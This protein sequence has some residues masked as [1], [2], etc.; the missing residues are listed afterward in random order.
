M[1]NIENTPVIRWISEH[2]L[3]W[4]D[5]VGPNKYLQALIVTVIFLLLAKMADFIKW[6][7]LAKV[8]A[9]TSTKVDDYVVKSLH[10]P[11]KTT[12]V[13]IGLG[14]ATLLLELPPAGRYLVIGILRTIVIFVWLRFAIQVCSD[15][16][17]YVSKNRDRSELV[18]AAT[19]PLFNNVS[20]IALIALAIYVFM[21]AWEINVTAWLASAGIVGLALSFAA[22]D[23]I[24]NLFAGMAILVDAPYKLGDF[25]IL[26]TG[27]RGEVTSIGM[28]ST[29]ILTLEDV[30]IT[31]PNGLMGNSKIINQSGGPHTK[32]R[33]QIKVSCAYGSDIDHVR[34]LLMNAAEEEPGVCE[35][36]EPRV[37]FRSFGDSG[38][39]FALL[40]WVELP[41]MR[42]EIEDNLNCEIYKRFA[43]EGIEIPY[44]K[45]DVYV[46]HV[47]SSTEAQG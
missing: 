2:Y 19:L 16:L 39:A 7:V 14:I 25:I 13:M 21:L 41:A 10:T 31:I 4:V 9:R 37:R 26:D 34:R 42:G 12:V 43:Q 11:L 22:K 24:A 46:R 47:P 40:C 29:R 17:G 30:E 8:A 45:R 3:T 23:T 28:R 5:I 35:S 44:P 6:G 33:I 38:L 27:E 15:I 18:Q 32:N 36:P 20:K 1:E